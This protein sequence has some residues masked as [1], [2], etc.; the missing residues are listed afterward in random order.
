M[1]QW[2]MDDF[3]T[4]SGNIYFLFGQIHSSE[5]QQHNRVSMVGL[6]SWLVVYSLLNTHGSNLDAVQSDCHS[7]YTETGELSVCKYVSAKFY[8]FL[9]FLL[10]S[11]FSF[12]RGSP[13]CVH[14]LKT[15]FLPN[16]RRKLLNCSTWPHLLT[17]WCPRVK[18]LHIYWTLWEIAQ[19][20]LKESNGTVPC[21]H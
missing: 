18:Q 11:I 4:F 3:F 2:H 20:N 19:Y 7:W 12:V 5:V 21:C 16:Q 1:D 9:L 8:M 6:R 17:A 14:Q 10:K 13:S 15:L